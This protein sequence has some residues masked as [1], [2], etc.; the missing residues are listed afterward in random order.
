M[1]DC[2]LG[3]SACTNSGRR[4]SGPPRDR[5]EVDGQRGRCGAGGHAAGAA[6]EPRHGNSG[7]PGHRAG[8]GWLRQC[9]RQRHARRP[10]HQWQQRGHPDNGGELRRD[11]ACPGPSCS[12]GSDRGG[13]SGDRV[14]AHGPGGAGRHVIL[15]P[16]SDGH[17]ARA[18]RSRVAIKSW[19]CCK[20]P[21]LVRRP[22]STYHAPAASES[23]AEDPQRLTA[24]DSAHS[25]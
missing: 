4:R 22:L 2:L 15:V 3:G 11:G 19:I 21:A 24:A 20:L 16:K 5:L 1:N 10:R 13:G 14:A 12:L 23:G 9:G 8:A 7:A 18:A 17:F 25:V 6:R